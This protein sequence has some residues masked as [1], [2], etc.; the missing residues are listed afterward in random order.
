ML[1]NVIQVLQKF[2]VLISSV[3]YI[4]NISNIYINIISPPIKQPQMSSNYSMTK[5]RNP[6]F[7]KQFIRLIILF[8]EAKS[9][10]QKYENVKFI[11]QLKVQQI[12]PKCKSMKMNSDNICKK[13]SIGM[14][15]QEVSQLNYRV[16]QGQNHHIPCILLKFWTLYDQYQALKTKYL[17]EKL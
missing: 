6:T 10:I 3:P 9:K 1:K 8:P 4:N 16:M 5:F 13:Y 15:V 17:K 7:I 2:F 14:H 12:T 11:F